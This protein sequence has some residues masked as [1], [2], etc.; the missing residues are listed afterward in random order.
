MASIAS[1]NSRIWRFTWEAL[2]HIPTLRL[3]LFRECFDPSVRCSTLGAFLR[4]DESLLLV[5]WTDEEE[6][7]R[8]VSLRVPVPRV[9]IDP[10]CPVDCIAKSDHI[11]IKLVLILPV[12]HPVMANFYGFLDSTGVEEGK[13][14]D[15]S[16]GRLLPLS[17]D[18]DELEQV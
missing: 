7:N 2:A 11:A 16:P 10:E 12:D 5:S 6:G 15:Q 9:L 14:G 1:G 3:Y 4:F 13:D 18:S 17:L 8:E